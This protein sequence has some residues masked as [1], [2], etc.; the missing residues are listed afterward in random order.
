MKCGEVLF[1]SKVDNWNNQKVFNERVFG[2]KQ[3]V[4]I[5]EDKKGNKFGGF[6]NATIDKIASHEKWEYVKD[7][8]SFLFS[9]RSNERLNGMMKFESIE[10]G[11]AMIQLFKHDD[12]DAHWIIDFGFGDLK[13]W[14][15]SER[16]K[17]CCNRNQAQYDFHGIKYPFTGS[18]G[19]I[20]KRFIVIQML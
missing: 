15:Y 14:D 13:I 1:D 9:L 18:Q 12:P 16:D 5:C 7:P 4:F 19:F 10:E 11:G 17:S 2:K 3:I 20:L 8:Q 6:I